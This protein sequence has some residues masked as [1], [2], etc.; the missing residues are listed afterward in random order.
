MSELPQ[1]S[2]DG[3]FAIRVDEFEDR[4]AVEYTTHLVDRAANR[5]IARLGGPL[6]CG[7]RPDG[8]LRIAQPAWN[9]WDVLV[10]P[11][12]ETFRIRDDQPWLPLAAWGLG[13]SAYYR[14]WANGIDFR[15]NDPDFG[16]PWV[17]TWIALGAF[18]ALALLAWKPWLDLVARATLIVIAAIVAIGFAWIAGNGW[19]AHASV[20]QR[21]VEPPRVPPLS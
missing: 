16:A 21:R 4:G 2:P 7:F 6:D 11:A 13:E 9:A 19:R 12:R 14:G 17:E 18:A 8:L 1:V 5:D 10:D 20:K 3:R 15:R